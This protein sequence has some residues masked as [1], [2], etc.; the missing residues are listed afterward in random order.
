MLIGMSRYGKTYAAR[1]MARMM[2]EDYAKIVTV[3][4]GCERKKRPVE[5]AFFE[6]MLEA[7]DHTDVYS[8]TNGA[9]RGRLISHLTELVT[10]SGQNLIV[11][12]V[13]EAQR[14]DLLEYEWLWDVHDKLERRGIRMITFLVGQQKLLNQKSALKEQGEHQIVNRLMVDELQFHGLR[15]AEEVA[16]CLAGYD[17]SC[18]PAD[19]DWTY[20]RF[21]LPRAYADGLR[22]ADDAHV[23][24]DAF[25]SAHEGAGFRFKV[26]IPMAY[27]SRAVEI[28]LMDYSEHDNAGF[29]LSPAIW[30]EVVR[31]SKYVAATE[32]SRFNPN[33]DD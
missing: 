13:D 25:V 6:N 8:G 22:L 1:W 24:W 3:T 21:F 19:T 14:L 20:T 16:S 31:N 30:E 7:A 12:F 17:E 18:F 4:L 29:K 26:D 15:S 11:F 2:K 10:R 33:A 9:K 28:A 32:D 5:S 27:F 23:V